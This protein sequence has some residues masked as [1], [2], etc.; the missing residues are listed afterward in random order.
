MG[1]WELEHTTGHLYWS[2]EIFTIYNLQAH[3]CEPNYALWA[4]LIYEPD[5]EFVRNTYEN[6]VQTG[7]EYDIRHRIIAGNAVK[8]IQARGVTYYDEQGQPVRTIGTAQ[9][10][11]EIKASQ[12]KI[13]FMAYHDVLTGL[14]NRKYF[15]DTLN[16]SLTTD[17]GSQKIIAVLFTRV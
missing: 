6:A 2:E 17:R 1:F 13:E 11:S 14:A 12:E 3:Q 10:I 4:S 16:Q 8:W 9:D 7:Q 15:S 5:R